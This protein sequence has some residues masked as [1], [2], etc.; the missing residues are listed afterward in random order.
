MGGGEKRE[1]KRRYKIWVETKCGERKKYEERQNM[2]KNKI[3]RVKK[4]ER[5]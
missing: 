2:G 1:N 3:K 5:K 4:E